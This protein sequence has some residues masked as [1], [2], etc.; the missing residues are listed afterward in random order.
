[1]NITKRGKQ[2][3]TGTLVTTYHARVEQLPSRIELTR[4]LSEE[5]RHSLLCELYPSGEIVLS[6]RNNIFKK[7][8]IV[9]NGKKRRTL[10]LVATKQNDLT[11]IKTVLTWEMF[12]KTRA[13]VKPTGVKIKDL[14]GDLRLN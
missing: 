11:I 2:W 6:L 10:V 12:Q 5:E 13:A 8:R 4:S 7:C 9:S 1:M 14:V 3:L